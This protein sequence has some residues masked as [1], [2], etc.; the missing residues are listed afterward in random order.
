MTT[1]SSFFD[2]LITGGAG[3][4]RRSIVS[5]AH[6]RNGWAASA[7]NYTS[8]ARSAGIPGITLTL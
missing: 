1:E 6:A 3:R 8:S 5:T 4:H 2:R 7:P